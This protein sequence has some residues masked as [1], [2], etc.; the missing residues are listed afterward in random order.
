MVSLDNFADNMCVWR[1]IAVYQGARPDRCTQLAGQLARGFFKLDIVPRTCL[2]ELD[3]VEGYLNKRKTTS[4]MYRNQGVRARAAR[5][6]GNLLASQKEPFWQVEKHHDNWN[7]RGAR[8]FD[9]RH[10]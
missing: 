1:S 3:K 5:K 6:W 4:R 10:H 2:D 7:L 8:I 9:Q